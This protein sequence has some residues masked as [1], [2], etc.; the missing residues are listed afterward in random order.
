MR[1]NVFQFKLFSIFKFIECLAIIR[2][3]RKNLGKSDI[4]SI[5]FDAN[6]TFFIMKT[7]IV[8]FNSNKIIWSEKNLNCPDHH[9]YFVMSLAST[10]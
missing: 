8:Q 2:T 10:T 5:H 6:V 7:H 9:C 3:D 1:L 4:Y